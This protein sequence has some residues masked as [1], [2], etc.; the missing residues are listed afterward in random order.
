ML[1]YGI[2]QDGGM[3]S[4]GETSYPKNMQYE[5]TTNTTKPERVTGKKTA[6]RWPTCGEKRRP[7]RKG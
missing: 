5:N 4:E 7:H 6:T 2:K 1:V 3:R